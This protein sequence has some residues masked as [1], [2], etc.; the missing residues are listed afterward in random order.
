MNESLNIKNKKRTWLIKA[1]EKK[2]FT[3]VEVAELI[4]TTPQ[5]YN[6]IENGLRR[7][8]P[9][10]AKKIAKVLDFD[11]TKFYETKPQMKN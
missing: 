7:P 10:V 9:E 8:S 11:W 5:F 2:I 6:Y 3:Q 1:R 4:G